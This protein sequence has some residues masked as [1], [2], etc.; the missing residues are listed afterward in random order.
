MSKLSGG[1]INELSYCSL[2]YG[3]ISA[4]K[5]VEDG[6]CEPFGAT[7]RG[8]VYKV[9]KKIDRRLT[10]LQ[11]ELWEFMAIYANESKRVLSKSEKL[12]RLALSHI[13]DAIQLDY[14]AIMILSLRFQPHERNMPLNDAFKWITKKE[15]SLYEIL[16]LL[17]ETKCSNKESEMYQLANLIVRDL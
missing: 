11:K 7:K 15:S 10:K 13:T 5:S 17:G 6:T 3:L 8:A 16:D 4:S 9:N 2:A 14:L 12:F 1:F